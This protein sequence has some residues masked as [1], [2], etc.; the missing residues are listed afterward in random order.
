MILT[1]LKL[2]KC[3]YRKEYIYRWVSNGA[4]ID[5]CKGEKNDFRDTQ[6]EKGKLDWTYH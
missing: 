3:G 1:K 5:K 4:G 6:E 2:L